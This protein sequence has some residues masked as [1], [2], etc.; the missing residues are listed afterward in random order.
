MTLQQLEVPIMG[1][2]TCRCLYSLNPD[3]EDPQI[4]H[5]DMMCAGHAEGKKDACQVRP[6]GGEVGG[7]TQS[8]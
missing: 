6:Y 8:L 2:D 7:S 5:N 1:I 3:P 4:I